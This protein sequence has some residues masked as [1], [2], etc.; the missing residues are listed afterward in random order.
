MKIKQADSP[1]AMEGGYRIITT[2]LYNND[3]PIGEGTE[4]QLDTNQLTDE[5]TPL[6]L[7]MECNILVNQI[8]Q[9]VKYVKIIN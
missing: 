9:Q 2:W 7:T 5:T 4:I 1:N 8:Q 6:E 3:T